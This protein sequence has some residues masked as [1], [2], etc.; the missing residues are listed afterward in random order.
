MVTF[1]GRKNLVFEIF[2]TRFF[3]QKGWV[4]GQRFTSGEE[5]SLKANGRG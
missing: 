1:D 3:V 5:V 4:L 2:K